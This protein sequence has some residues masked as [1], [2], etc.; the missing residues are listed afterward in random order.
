MTKTP[1]IVSPEI[2]AE[3]TAEEL[4]PGKGVTLLQRVIMP[5]AADPLKVRTLYFDEGES[6]RAK[7][8]DRESAQVEPGREISFAAYFNAFPATYW[9]RWTTLTSVVLRLDLAG[10]CRV[11]VYR[12]KA[13]GTT[14]HVTGA[15]TEPGV[16]NSVLEFDLDLSPFEDGGWYW[17]D[18]TAGDEPATLRRAGWYAD[19]EPIDAA[20]LAI[21]ICTHNRPLDCVAALSALAGDPLVLDQIGT[22]VVTDQGTDKVMDAPR[23]AEVAQALGTRL[24]LVEQPNL[25]GS[26]GFSRAMYEVVTDSDATHLIFLDDDIELEPDSVQ[27]AFAFARFAKH[28]MLVGGQMLALQNRS[29]LHTMGEVVQRD[30]FF[31]RGAP[32]TCYGHDFSRQTLREAKHLHRRIDVDYNGWW[33]CLIP[34]TVIERIGLPLPLFIKWDDAE[35]GLRAG[36][37]GFPTATL[38]GVAIWH[39]S[40]TDK[41]DATDWQAYFHVRNRLIAAALHSPFRRGGKLLKDTFKFD[42]KYLLTLQYSTTALHH[43]AYRDFLAGPDRLFALLPSAL[44][45][46]RERRLTYVD[47]VTRGS[48]SELPLPSM[49]PVRA[50]RFLK[51]P[52]NPLTIGRTLAGALVHNLK[53]RN[54]SLEP[55]RPQLNVAAKDATWFLL[56][57]LDSATVATAD[58][59]GV[60]LRRRDPHQ[61]WAMLGESVRLHRQLFREFPKLRRRYRDAAPGLTSIEGWR[62]I[63]QSKP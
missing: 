45:T 4:R 52:T 37:A 40:W 58:G 6:S 30:K 18:V 35:Y 20:K 10:R 8:L 41:D 1:E 56:A 50:E 2:V 7:L 17:F 12:S 43:L 57:R 3:P 34:R 32:K 27:R 38:P 24:R 23:F 25:G 63:F 55:D 44:P 14:I 11:D 5:R 36:V 21:G 15:T 51:P 22:V 19:R 60:T 39:L 47:G 42:L 16:T 26:G 31:W 62:P 46:V 33:M 28:P 54:R 13:D 48:S 53:P 9:R 29:V 61:F 49:S 59:R